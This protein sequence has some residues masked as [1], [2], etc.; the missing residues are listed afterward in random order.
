MMKKP[1]TPIFLSLLTLLTINSVFSQ[2]GT[3]DQS[4][5]KNGKTTTDIKGLNDYGNSVTIQNDKKI[6]VAGYSWD[7]QFISQGIQLVRYETNGEVDL[8]FGAN[9]KV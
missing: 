6:I 7:N 3:L 5:G 2:P 8:S 9:G 4:F 1:L